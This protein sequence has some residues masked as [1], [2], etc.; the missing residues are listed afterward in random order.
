MK[1]GLTKHQKLALLIG[2]IK[3]AMDDMHYECDFSKIPTISFESSIQEYTVGEINFFLQELD[4][5]V[6]ENYHR[7]DKGLITIDIFNRNMC[8]YQILFFSI[9]WFC[10]NRECIGWHMTKGYRVIHRNK[11]III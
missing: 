1:T 5:L 9:R 3:E 7:R 2:R 6:I 8:A 4:R 11:S 10:E